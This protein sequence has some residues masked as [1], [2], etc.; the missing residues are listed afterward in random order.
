MQ[1]QAPQTHAALDATANQPIEQRDARD[2]Q[3]QAIGLQLANVVQKSGDLNGLL[4]GLVRIILDQSHCNGIWLGSAKLSSTK[5]PLT[6]DSQPTSQQTSFVTLMQPDSLWPVVESQLRSLTESAFATQTVCQASLD[7]HTNTSLVVAPILAIGDTHSQTQ[8]VLTGCFNHAEESEL[9]QQWLMSMAAQTISQ[10]Q[11][12]RL[13]SN[14]SAVNQNLHKAFGLARRLSQ[15]E[16][17]PAAARVMVN[18]LQTVLNCSQ[19][20]LSLCSDAKSATISAISGVEQVDVRSEFA[21]QTIAAFQQPLIEDQKLEFLV[22]SEKCSAAELALENYC[23][24]SGCDGVIAVPMSDAS[25]NQTGSVLVG[26]E[27]QQFLDPAFHAS[28]QQ[29]IDL[30]AGHLQTVLRANES[31]FKTALSRVD[32][33]KKSATARN[34]AIAVAV[35]IG[36]LLVPMPYRVWCDCNVQP[37]ERR[38]IAAPFEGVLAESLV[39]S[40]DQVA[41]QQ[42]VARLDGRLL[43][44]ELAGIQAEF[45]VAKKRRDLALASGDVAQSQIAKSEMQRHQAKVT[46]LNQRLKNLEVR[47]PID[48][49]VVAGDLEKAVGVPL[50]LGQT[51]FEIGPL[52]TMVAEIGVPE[53]E[54]HYVKPGMSVQLK[55]DSFPFQTFSAEIQRV[56]PRA[57]EVD[58]ASVFIADVVLE[59]SAGRLRPGMSGSAKVSSGWSPLGW[60]LFHHPWESLRYWTIW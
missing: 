5:E 49:V 33:L 20:A 24:A 37:V 39:R 40:G 42:I 51:L 55:F 46:I 11:Q 6:A 38:F 48:G 3:Q 19:V 53:S 44:G 26:C 8:L 35:L 45:D 34:A 32:K 21:D 12:T 7:G 18:H 23:I 59:N 60:N 15:T 28:C 54:A 1:P 4:Q 25:G 31:L 41:A 47:S 50:E 36:V 9:R 29:I 30:V 58:D 56:H 10:W 43:R 14:Q 16:S 17:S 57:E 2:F 52:D 27:K 22:G 13:V